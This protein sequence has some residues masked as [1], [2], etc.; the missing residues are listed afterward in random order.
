MVKTPELSKQIYSAIRYL[1]GAIFI[2]YGVVKILGIQLFKLHLH[3]DI[4]GFDSVTLVWYFFGYSQ[5][6]AKF[7]ALAELSAGILIILPRT[8]RL[9]TLMIFGM[10]LNI[11]VMDYCFNFPSVKYMVTLYTLLALILL[12]KD[13]RIY[14][15]VF[16][17]NEDL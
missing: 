9:G 12:L 11:T 6:Y 7:I 1:L 14:K 4:N 2:V 8:A 10:G 3:G 17:N 13:Y 16:L 5:V 15:R